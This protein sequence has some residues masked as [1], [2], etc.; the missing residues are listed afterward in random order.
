M[1]FSLHLSAIFRATETGGDIKPDDIFIEK[2][3]K[4]YANIA[5]FIYFCYKFSSMI[6]LFPFICTMLRFITRWTKTQT[7][8]HRFILNQLNLKVFS[9]VLCST[10]FFN[11]LTLALRF[12]YSAMRRQCG[13]SNMKKFNCDFVAWRFFFFLPFIPIH[14]Q[15]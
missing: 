13:N 6:R 12:V 1:V 15:Q 2:Y 8:C 3:A 4:K 14:F 10:F 9:T 5:R 7:K 11:S